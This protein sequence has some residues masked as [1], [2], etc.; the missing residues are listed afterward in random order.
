MNKYFCKKKK[1][2]P[3]DFCNVCD[4]R[5]I[6]L[7]SEIL[8]KKTHFYTYHFSSQSIICYL[9]HVPMGIGNDQHVVVFILKRV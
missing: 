7:K 2:Q 3:N 5:V 6:V 1:V 8:K 4:G 9:E